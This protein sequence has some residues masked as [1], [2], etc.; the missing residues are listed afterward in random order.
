MRLHL[1]QRTSTGTRFGK[2]WLA[3]CSTTSK[4]RHSIHS[5]A[6]GRMYSSAK[7]L[8]LQSLLAPRIKQSMHAGSHIQVKPK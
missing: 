3:H 4:A 7:W 6:F 5:A 1:L 2:K 8:Y